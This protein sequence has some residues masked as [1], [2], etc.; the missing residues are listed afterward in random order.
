MIAK[1]CCMD[2][3]SLIVYIKAEKIYVDNVK[4]NETRFDTSIY[5]LDRPISKGKSKKDI[6]LMKDE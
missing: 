6:V 3:D 2:T 4:V 5:E 1:L